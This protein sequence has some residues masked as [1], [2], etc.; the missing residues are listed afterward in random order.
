MIIGLSWRLSGALA[1]FVRPLGLRVVMVAAASA[2]LVPARAGDGT[3]AWVEGLHARARLIAVGTDMS[4]AANALLVG[5][6]VDLEPGWHTYW[7]MPGDAG[8]P[9]N[10]DWSGSRN[11]TSAEILWPAPQR[12]PDAY[13]NSIGY[14]DE[15]VFPVLVRPADPDRPVDLA[16]VFSYAVCAEVCVPE[17][18]EMVLR[19]HDSLAPPRAV[20][21]LISAYLERVPRPQGDRGG[22]RVERSW[23]AAERDG[24]ELFI[25]VV[26]EAS[27]ALFVEGPEPYYFG[28][29]RPA[30]GTDTNRRRFRVPVGGVDRPEDVSGMRLR[31]TLV[32]NQG[33]VDHSWTVE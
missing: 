7:R 1:R 31:A 6:Q 8:V 22:P 2:A 32:T 9:P 33:N 30:G 26:S 3:S 21:S 24:V 29:P 16:V 14:L 20:R 4:V 10:F 12:L 23:A 18:A 13:G 15:V 11:M 17:R 28:V 5:V 25:E 27:A 19:V